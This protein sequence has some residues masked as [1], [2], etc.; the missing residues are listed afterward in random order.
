M[1]AYPATP[2]ALIKTLESTLDDNLPPTTLLNEIRSLLDHYKTTLT[3]DDHL[4]LKMIAANDG[5]GNATL[6]TIDGRLLRLK[7]LYTDSGLL[8][9]IIGDETL[10]IT[11]EAR[12]DAQIEVEPI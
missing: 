12:I 1:T 4:V 10:E 3:P 6:T 11:Y 9:A 5:P 7:D 2:A 8:I